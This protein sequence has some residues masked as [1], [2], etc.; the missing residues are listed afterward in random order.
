MSS[1]LYRKYRSKSLDEIVGQDHITRTLK[2]A[3]KQGKI[4][5][6]YLL[7]GPRGVGKTSI[8]R[9]LAHEINDLKYDSDDKIHLDII[10]IDAASNRRIDEIRDLRDKVHIAP[11]SAKYKVYII[12]EVHML[13]KE[14][15]NAL[16]KTLEEPPAHC[17]FILATTEL[18][19]VP[20]TIISRTQSYGFKSVDREAVARHLRTIADSEKINIS[21]EALQLVAEHGGGSFRDSISILDQV[22]STTENKITPEIVSESLGIAPTTLIDSLL[23]SVIS[24]DA[25][26][27]TTSLEDITS[28]NL[29]PS[30]VAKQLIDKLRTQLKSGEGSRDMLDLIDNLLDVSASSQPLIK[31]ELTLYKPCALPKTSVAVLHSSPTKTIDLPETEKPKP[32]VKEPSEPIK[33]KSAAKLSEVDEVLT[34]ANSDKSDL[35]KKKMNASVDTAESTPLTAD[36]WM[37]IIDHVRITSPSQVSSLRLAEPILQGEKLL[38]RFSQAFHQKRNSQAKIKDMIG[39]AAEKVIGLPLEIVSI[40]EKE[41][42]PLLQ[43]TFHA[44]DL[45]AVTVEQIASIKSTVEKTV[46]TFKPKQIPDKVVNMSVAMDVF[47]N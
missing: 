4:S 32:K 3:I 10:E 43:T 36:I 44:K 27:L 7:S 17:V 6:A 16:L 9:I 23:N 19:K 14:A 1:A 26:S 29:N 33:P 34:N 40:L 20:E 12:D 47:G 21:D 37:Q 39:K 28:R 2:S 30:V 11:T 15:F 41:T 5:H 35:D 24:A 22:S 31:L 42:V 13:T 8:A 18:H 25:K 38:L 45:S 46:S